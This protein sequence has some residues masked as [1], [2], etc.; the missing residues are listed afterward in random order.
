MDWKNRGERADMEI[1]AY[2]LSDY[3][4]EPQNVTF[5]GLVA[6]A[7]LLEEL[8]KHYRNRK[9]MEIW[10]RQHKIA[11]KKRKVVRKKSKVKDFP[12]DKKSGY[13]NAVWEE[14]RK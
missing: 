3:F 12:V 4:S 14:M 11:D 7:L 2:L 13:I 6:V 10:L 8:I 5:W 1:L 9:R